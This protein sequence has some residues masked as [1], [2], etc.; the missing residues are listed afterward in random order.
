MT[1]IL[2]V[3]MN[4]SWNENKKEKNIKKLEFTIA[5]ICDNMIFIW[6]MWDY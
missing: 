5:D 3:I 4:V 2:R 6:K 1:S